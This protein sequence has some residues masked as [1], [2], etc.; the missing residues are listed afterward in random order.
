MR[1]YFDIAR[2][3]LAAVCLSGAISAPAADYPFSKWSE[4]F[5]R[6]KSRPL[7]GAYDKI[8][9]GGPDGSTL[10]TF[11]YAGDPRRSFD[12]GVTWEAFTIAGQGT[13]RAWDVSIAPQDARVWY[14]WGAQDRMLHRTSDGGNTWS[15]R[16]GPVPID[17]QVYS[18]AVSADP[19]VI[20][21]TLLEL[22]LNCDFNEC[23]AKSGTLQV[24]KDGGASWQDI[25]SPQ[26]FQRAFASPIDPNV[27]FAVGRNG[28]Q[29]S[30]DQG[31]T[32]VPVALPY[33]S[34]PE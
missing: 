20:Y 5:S 22:D 32:W 23:Q 12:G 16:G 1:S 15:T 31:A 29:R 3:L 17:Q 33:G 26:Y 13:Q 18:A 30:V 19:N 6:W 8:V 34:S 27:V 2:S 4:Q 24:S 25:G 11:P 9:S 21:R 28:L 10:I 14:A 7:P